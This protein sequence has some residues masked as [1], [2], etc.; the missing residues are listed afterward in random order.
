[1]FESYQE[2]FVELLLLAA[3]LMFEALALLDRI[4]LLRIGG[5]NFL[6][7]NS[8]LK[9][10]DRGRILGGELG[11][12][13]PLFWGVGEKGGGKKNLVDE[14]F[15]ESARHFENFLNRSEIA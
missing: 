1:M 11:Q 12:R 15:E 5:G 7:V 14:R 4:V 3:G 2:I 13:H 10:I 8:A 6:A 9:K